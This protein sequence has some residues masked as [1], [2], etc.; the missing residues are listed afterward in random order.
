MKKKLK[1][2]APLI[3]II[4]GVLYLLFAPKYGFI[5]IVSEGRKK[6]HLEREIKQLNVE[7]LLLEKKIERL[8]SDDKYIEKMIREQL[9]MIKHGEKIYKN[10]K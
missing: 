9:N 6:S 7:I 8:K 4:L 5:H 3:L 1:K 10:G 2:Y